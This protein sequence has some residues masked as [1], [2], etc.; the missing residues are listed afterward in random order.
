VSRFLFVVL[1]LGGH[2]NAPLAVS[3]ALLERGHQVAWCGPKSFLRPL[4]GPS[5][6]VYPTGV[7]VYREQNLHG[8][9]ALTSLWDN[10]LVPLAHFVLPKVERAVTAWRPDVVIVDQHAV[11]GALVAR[12]HRL[13]WAS[14]VTGALELTGPSGG[15][16]EVEE[17]VQTRLSGLR[18]L[19]DLPPDDPVDPRFSPHLVIAFTTPALTGAAVLP[20]N[21]VL[22]GPALGRR[23]ADPPFPWTWLDP[24][25][26]HVLVTVGTLAE[27]I[28]HEFYAR[29]VSALAA[30]EDRLQG[31][32]V[33]PAGAV[34]G[35]PSN[36]LLADRV[37][38]LELMPRLDAVVCHAGMGTVGEALAH[39]VPLVLA[40]IRHDQ[41]IVADQVVAA[42][43][44]VRVPFF[45]GDPAGL[46]AAVTAVL[47]EPAYRDAALRV[48]DSFASAGGA[49][50][51]AEH[52]TALAQAGNMVQ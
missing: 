12:R 13:R 35:P 1:P 50:A 8:A 52:L 45:G 24:R 29:A 10:Y 38:M 7:R 11:A 49:S 32:V 22:V 17:L 33:A 18:E 46:R 40:P 44:G 25:C 47:D 5:A 20:D 37:P 26:R 3:D 34:P 28:A 21:C 16:R 31:I 51:A 30:P 4:V 6:V 19:A 42:G 15:V 43:A 36:L 2:I 48:R 41:P 39:G 27:H 23:P 9:A 14:L